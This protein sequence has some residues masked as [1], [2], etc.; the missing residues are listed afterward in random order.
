M[1]SS[2]Y[3][4]AP[5]YLYHDIDRECHA[6]LTPDW[7]HTTLPATAHIMMASALNIECPGKTRQLQQWLVVVGYVRWCLI[8][9]MG[10]GGG[11]GGVTC[12]QSAQFLSALAHMHHW[13]SQA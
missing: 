11:G 6:I 3:L 2:L 12:E 10:G 5:A 13:L 7:R 8:I 1:A 4:P 9:M